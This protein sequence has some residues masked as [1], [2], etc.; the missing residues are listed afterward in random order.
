MNPVNPNQSEWNWIFRNHSDRPDS[1]GLKFIPKQS[2][3]F[4]IIPEFVSEPY[5]FIPI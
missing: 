1:F 4:R 5:S 2:E 3:I